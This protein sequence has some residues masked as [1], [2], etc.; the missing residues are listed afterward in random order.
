MK[1]PNFQMLIPAYFKAQIQY[2]VK[3]VDG[4]FQQFQ[5]FQQVLNMNEL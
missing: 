3:Y 5:Q 4:I 1:K 2:V